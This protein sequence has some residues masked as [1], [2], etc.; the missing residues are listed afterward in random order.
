MSTNDKGTNGKLLF[1]QR[2]Q[3]SGFYI[4]ACSHQYIKMYSSDESI[5]N[6]YQLNHV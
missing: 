4:W 6:W 1:R 3:I 5:I 2:K